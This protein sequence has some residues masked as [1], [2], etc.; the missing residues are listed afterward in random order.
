M[1]HVVRGGGRGLLA[2]RKPRRI[3][4]AG[5]HQYSPK[6]M[7]VTSWRLRLCEFSFFPFFLL[8]FPERGGR[9]LDAG[10][11]AFKLRF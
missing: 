6:V 9:T 1:H 3:S 7:V 4:A 10:G 8:S 2:G 11:K 5:W